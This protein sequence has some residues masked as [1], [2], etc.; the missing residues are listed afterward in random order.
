MNCSKTSAER[1][2]KQFMFSC[3]NRRLYPPDDLPLFLRENVFQVRKAQLC[4]RAG[5]RMTRRPPS[6]ARVPNKHEPRQRK[7][8][9]RCSQ[10][11]PVH[12][13]SD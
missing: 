6:G 2:V 1:F 5:E 4:A 7:A 8:L 3:F 12:S 11:G 9:H 13:A 10:P